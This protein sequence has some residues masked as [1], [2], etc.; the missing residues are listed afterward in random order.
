[1]GAW[2]IIPYAEKNGLNAKEITRAGYGFL[3]SVTTKYDNDWEEKVPE[4]AE[5]V[6]TT[7]Y[8]PQK[9]TATFWNPNYVMKGQNIELE[10][11]E[12]TAGKGTAVWKLP[13]KTYHFDTIPSESDRK[14]YTDPDTKDGYY[15]ILIK[16]EGAGRNDLNTCITKFVEIY[17]GMYDDIYTRPVPIHEE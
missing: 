1:R 7:Y 9:V 5:K 3:F 10:R 13:L 14:W 16:V 2:E 8:G 15:M 17:G 12:G 4:K 11:V 6:G